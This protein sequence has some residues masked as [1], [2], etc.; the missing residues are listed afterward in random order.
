MKN[1]IILIFLIT[2]AISGFGQSLT[3][4]GIDKTDFPKIKA[5]FFAFDANGNTILNLKNSD[6]D[7]E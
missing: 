3:F 4:F 6:F 1:Y 2:S 7:I 5:K